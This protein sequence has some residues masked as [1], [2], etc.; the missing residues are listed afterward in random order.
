MEKLI[1]SGFFAGQD[2]NCAETVLYAANEKFGWNLPHE[3]LVMSAGF[4]GGVGGQELLCGALSGGVMVIGRLFVRNRGHE[5]DLNKTII[6]E[7]FA[8]FEKEMGSTLCAPLKKVHRTE[9]EG[10]RNVILASA[11]A[12]DTIVQNHRTEL[13]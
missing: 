13:A 3:A 1:T 9:A 7:Y 12:L 5:S 6:R 10:C 11:R 4:G 8:L 2:L